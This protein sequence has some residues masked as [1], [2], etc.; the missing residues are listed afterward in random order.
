M[1]QSQ[2]FFRCYTPNVPPFTD[3]LRQL[4]WA[5]RICSSSQ[6]QLIPV[7]YGRRSKPLRL[8][9][10]PYSLL[11]TIAANDAETGTPK[12]ESRHADGTVDDSSTVLPNF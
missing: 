3:C 9:V 7:P 11:V 8:H 2:K 12:D 5:H 10:A 4:R 6:E 1:S